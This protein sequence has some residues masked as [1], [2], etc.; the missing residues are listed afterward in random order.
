MFKDAH[1]QQCAD[2]CRQCAQ[3]CKNLANM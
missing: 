2:I 3:E 1:Y